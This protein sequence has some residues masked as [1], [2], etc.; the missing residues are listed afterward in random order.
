M[1]EHGLAK[2]F[3]PQLKGIAE[4]NAL[5]KVTRLEMIVGMLHGV[6]GEVLSHSFEHVFEGTIFEGAAVQITVVDPGQ[7]FTPPGADESMTANGWELLV[8]RMEGE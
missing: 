5:S 1:H 3:W 7:E 4:I 2:D 8:T 6:S